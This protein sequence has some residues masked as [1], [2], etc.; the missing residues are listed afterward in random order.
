MRRPQHFGL[1]CRRCRWRIEDGLTGAPGDLDVAV[2]ADEWRRSRLAAAV[3]YMAAADAVR[4][5]LQAVEWGISEPDASMRV[6][7]DRVKAAS[8]ECSR[9][10]LNDAR[11]VPSGPVER[12]RKKTTC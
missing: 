4:V 8:A 9:W 11:T 7:R 1:T 2:Q 3:E 6:A 10:G 12:R 5:L